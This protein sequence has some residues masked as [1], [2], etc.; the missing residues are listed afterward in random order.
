MR[1]QQTVRDVSMNDSCGND[2]C[3]IVCLFDSFNDERMVR[4][5]GP[6]P[7]IDDD[8]EVYPIH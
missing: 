1:K 4:C 6:A 3:S 5:W 8:D 2:G 7:M